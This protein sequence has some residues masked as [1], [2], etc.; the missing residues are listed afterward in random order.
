MLYFS[1]LLISFLITITLIPIA[2][3]AALSLNVIDMPNARKV[4]TSPIPRCGGVAMALGAM[5][6]VA[7]LFY[8]DLQHLSVILGAVVI[9]AF[10][11]VDDLLDTSYRVKMAGQTIAALVVILV[12]DV[13]IKSL[14]MLLPGDIA[15]PDY[16]AIPLTLFVIVGVTNAVNL[17]DGLDGLAGGISLLSFSLIGYLAFM[18]DN[19]F[20]LLMS[21]AMVGAIFGFLRFNNHPANLFMGD[22]GS[23]ML[24]FL[25]ITL[26]L[27][28]TQGQSSYSVLIPLMIAGVP[29]LDTLRVMF[30]RAREGRSVFSADR[31]HIHHRFMDMGLFQTE[32]VFIIYVLQT[33]LVITAF[34]F[35][36]HSEWSLLIIYVLFSAGL[37]TILALAEKKGWVLERQGVIDLVAIKNKLRIVFREE[38]MTLKMCFRFLKFMVPAIFMVSCLIPKE[39]PSYLSIMAIAYALCVVI[40]LLFRKKWLERGMIR[41]LLYLTIPLVLYYGEADRSSFFNGLFMNIYDVCF[42]GLVIP[43]AGV[44]KFTRRQKGFTTTPMDYLIFLIAL[45]VAVMPGI[46]IASTHMKLLATKIMILFFAYEVLIGELRGQVRRLAWITV[47]TLII[48][49]L[50]GVV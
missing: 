47:G 14:G 24:G 31:N 8:Q 34:L 5:V 43:A 30:R 45:A 22:A 20:V 15:L 41:F 19:Y 23:Q 38:R 3:R 49:G 6:P 28:L 12:G 10:G 16:I 35:R 39:V 18:A 1:T 4:H 2:R 40:L 48:L 42:L 50:K 36:F 32:T 21:F 46:G 27:S 37:I 25:T 17:S 11:V 26:S 7:F 29:V 33:F 13:T 9:V 44:I